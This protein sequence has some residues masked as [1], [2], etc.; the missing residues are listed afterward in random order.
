MLIP[1]TNMVFVSGETFVTVI[2]L[3]NTIVIKLERKIVSRTV[4]SN[5]KRMEFMK[6]VT[7]AMARTFP[8]D[9]SKG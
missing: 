8:V 7:N 9:L 6:S 1:F 5:L 3:P 4:F 2:K